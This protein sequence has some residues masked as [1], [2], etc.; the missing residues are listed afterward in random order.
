MHNT[1]PGI[2][3][4]KL[5]DSNGL[6]KKDF[7]AKCGISPV[8]LSRILNDK[9]D[10]TPQMAEKFAKILNVT[11]E[12]LL[13]ESES[14]D[15]IV[16]L[17][18]EIINS[19][20]QNKN[21]QLLNSYLSSLDF[22]FEKKIYIDDREYHWHIGHEYFVNPKDC[23]DFLMEFHIL[24]MLNNEPTPNIRYCIS[25]EYQNK[26]V[27]EFDVHEFFYMLNNFHR[28]SK[29]YFLNAAG[30]FEDPTLIVPTDSIYRKLQELKNRKE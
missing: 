26:I 27:K 14:Q 29:S 1:S 22:F 11:A 3:V 28:I 25:M 9:A 23:D 8:S 30:I 10:L 7:A 2:R 17:P 13:G 16:N 12:Y 24:D 5:I 18:Q 21:I 4:R 15:K 20:N 19:I 6:K